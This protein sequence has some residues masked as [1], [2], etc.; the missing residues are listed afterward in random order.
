MY[1]AA[2]VIGMFQNAFPYG[3][4]A[5]KSQLLYLYFIGIYIVYICIGRFI[6]TWII[7]STITM[8]YHIII[9]MTFSIRIEYRLY[10]GAMRRYCE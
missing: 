6:R 10:L 8:Y 4:Y 7:T 1:T 5:R 9:V 2:Q 3:N